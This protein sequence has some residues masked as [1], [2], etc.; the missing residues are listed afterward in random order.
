MTDTTILRDLAKRY[1]DVCAAPDQN[2]RRDLWRR[3]NSLKATRPLIR[4]PGACSASKPL[5]PST[6]SAFWRPIGWRL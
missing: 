6:A 5:P 4:R 2:V 1:A 3:H